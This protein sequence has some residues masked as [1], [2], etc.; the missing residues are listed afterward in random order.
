MQAAAQ[1][2]PINYEFMMKRTAGQRH[3]N[4]RGKDLA[5]S[6]G[7]GLCLRPACETKPVISPARLAGWLLSRELPIGRR[8]ALTCPCPQIM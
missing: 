2:G 6:H 5:V 3:G 4:P 8:Y 7:C 1:S